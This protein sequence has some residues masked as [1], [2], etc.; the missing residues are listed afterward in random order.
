MCVRVCVCVF[1]CAYFILHT[2][3]CTR[4]RSSAYLF[5]GFLP[6]FFLVFLSISFL[7]IL[8]ESESLDRSSEGTRE[9]KNGSAMSEDETGIGCKELD[10][11]HR[12]LTAPEH[13]LG[14]KYTTSQVPHPVGCCVILFHLRLGT[15][16]Q[17]HA[18]SLMSG[19]MVTAQVSAR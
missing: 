9:Y 8:P 12:S 15:D 14:G 5:L 11:L 7:S 18:R 16:R 3:S 13:T 10:G 6:I 19:R 2:N 17:R 4:P 1:V